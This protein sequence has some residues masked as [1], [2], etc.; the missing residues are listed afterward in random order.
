[1]CLKRRAAQWVFR[2]KEHETICDTSAFVTYTYDNGNLPISENGYATLDRKAHTLFMK[3]LR[4][5][6][7]KEGHNVKLKYY[8]VGEY[9]GQTERP[10]YH[11]ILFNLPPVYINNEHKLQKIWKHGNVSIDEVTGASIAYVC[12]YVN[13]QTFFNNLGSND[14]RVPE[15]NFMSKGL[16]ETYITANRIKSMKTKLNPFLTIED[17]LKISMPR[18]YKEKIF[19]DEEKGILQNKAKEH[20]ENNVIFDTDYDKQQF[21]KQQAKQRAKIAATKRRKL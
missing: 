15:F 14:D 9:G 4:K 12:G 13:K 1:M 3:R 16:G 2:L 11:S 20:L 10:H 21:I 5:Q 7:H 19:T 18:Y 6:L 8:L 17:G